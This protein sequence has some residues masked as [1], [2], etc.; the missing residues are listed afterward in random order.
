[1][2]T[3]DRDDVPLLAQAGGAVSSDVGGAVVGGSSPAA[4]PAAA[5]PAVAA[6]APA[7]AGGSG[8][9]LAGGVGLAVGVGVDQRRDDDKPDTTAPTL[10]ISDAVTAGFVTGAVVFSFSFS[11]AVSDFTIDD[12]LVIGGAK[13]VLSGSGATYSLT[14]TPAANTTGNL[15]V[16]VAAGAARDAAGNTS[17]AALA[18]HAFD[19]AAPTLSIS[20]DYA[21]LAVGDVVYT[22]RFSEPV[23]GFG[24][25]DIVVVGGSKGALSGD[26]TTYRMTVS[27]TAASRGEL[28]LSVAAG[29]VVDVAGNVSPGTVATTQSFN[30]SG[31]IPTGLAGVE[32][33]GGY[34]SFFL[35]DGRVLLV[36]TTGMARFL[37]DGTP[38]PTFSEDG[39]ATIA[40]A[41]K[42]HLLADGKL[43]VVGENGLARYNAD[44]SPDLGFGGDGTVEVAPGGAV[45]YFTDSTVLP[46]GKLLVFGTP[47]DDS[48]FATAALVRYNSDGSPDTGFSGDGVLIADFGER[49][50]RLEYTPLDDGKLL[51]AAAASQANAPPKS[52]LMRF[53]ADGSPD[54]SFSEDGIA[55]NNIA[56]DFRYYDGY[57]VLDDGGIMLLGWGGMT[58]LNSDGSLNSGFGVNGSVNLPSGPNSGAQIFDFQEDADGK[59]LVVADS[60]RSDPHSYRE[61]VTVLRYLA[62]GSLDSGFADGGSVTVE[63]GYNPSNF[64]ALESQADGKLLL[65]GTSVTWEVA[66]LWTYR[67]ARGLVLRFDQNGQPDP[68]FSGDGR[69]VFDYGDAFSVPVEAYQ[70]ADGKTVI[71]GTYRELATSLS[72]IGV[73]RLNADGS[74]DSLFSGD[75]IATL[76]ASGYGTSVDFRREPD[77]GLTLVGRDYYGVATLARLG[78]NGELDHDFG[79]PARA[80]LDKT[81]LS[82]NLAAVPHVAGFVD[83]ID[84]IALSRL[85]YDQLTI[86]D[87]TGAEAGNTVIGA[88]GQYLAVVMGMNPI[89]LSSADFMIV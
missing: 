18:E 63:R 28:S 24:A 38:D 85:S 32:A 48:Q 45:R 69:L 67:P 23:S 5:S 7:H 56:P 52:I 34:D 37:A 70:Q 54:F 33:L 71:V 47:R 81:S 66:G 42:P 80:V 78:A 22:F 30:T 40:F 44:G 8:W 2:A 86:A 1:M 89:N 68:G 14:V 88:N 50:Y 9:L 36:G 25:D 15:V 55:T 72:G 87:G 12:V 57:R 77:G 26:G 13:G 39:R 59:L 31:R 20:D 61:Y 3:A 35:D 84:R 17:V 41:G 76:P 27:P 51:V 83:G 29:A 6:S 16:S 10:H 46:D 19:S 82:S 74:L 43:L 21:G 79:A 75:G 62:D 49:V 4:S 73:A 64:I 53:N 65:L 58:R 11:E 60:Y